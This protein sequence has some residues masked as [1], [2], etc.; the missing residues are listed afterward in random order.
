[1]YHPSIYDQR[2]KATIVRTTILFGFSN[3]LY[4][5]FF[6]ILFQM[7]FYF[8]ALC[9]LVEP[10]HLQFT[11]VSTQLLPSCSFFSS[12]LC[13][14]VWSFRY[15][16]FSIHLPAR[17][18]QCSYFWVLA[19]SSLSPHLW[20]STTV[21][22]FGFWIFE[23]YLFSNWYNKNY[24]DVRLEIRGLEKIDEYWIPTLC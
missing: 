21:A 16:D 13:L 22:R 6:L 4:R 3:N 7:N 11:N 5:Y 12:L 10:S 15:R 9:L 17:H 19:L 2:N 8:P 20:F 1:M 23:L 14:A 18:C 24:E